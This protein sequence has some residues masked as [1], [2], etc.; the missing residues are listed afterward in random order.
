LSRYEDAIA[1]YGRAIQIDPKNSKFWL[2]RANVFLELARYQEAISDFDHALALKQDLPLV[3]GKRLHAKLYM[4]DWRDFDADCERLLAA[5]REGKLPASPGALAAVP[6]K[7]SDQLACAPLFTEKSYPAGTPLWT[8]GP[9]NHDR[10]RIAYVC[11]AFRDH[12]TSVLM[13]GLF[14]VHDRGQFHTVA[15]SL[16]PELR[17]SVLDRIKP[18][19]DEFV[20]AERM[21]DDEIAGVHERCRDRYRR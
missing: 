7:A 9:H 18:A 12:A 14:E 20:W 4:N 17:S 16:A 8:G 11:D 21:R 15:I 13:A 2:G 19:F 3:A 5:V 6:S 1:A 10:I